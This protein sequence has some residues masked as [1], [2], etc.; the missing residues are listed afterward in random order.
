MITVILILALLIAL[1]ILASVLIIKNQIKGKKSLQRQ[2]DY[3]DS[4]IDFYQ[5][6]RQAHQSVID[7][8]TEGKKL[9]ESLKEKINNS[10]GSN[11][12]DILN[13]L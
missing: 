5:K 10:D 2:L 11:L 12:A 9:D 6:N 1:S 7:K 4:R 3:A 13:E 8:L